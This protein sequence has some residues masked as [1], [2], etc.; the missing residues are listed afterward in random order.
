MLDKMIF[1]KMRMP[2]PGEVLPGRAEPIETAQ[3]HYVNGRAL[4][5]DWQAPLKKIMFGMGCFWG[6]ERLLWQQSGVY[7]TASGYAGG[8]TPNPTY[9]ETCTG[10]TG[11]AEVVLV[12]YNSEVLSLDKLLQIFWQAHDPTQ[13]MAQGADI[14]TSYRSAIYVEDNQDFEQALHSQKLY[15]QAL[16]EN[17]LAASQTEIA[18]NFPFYYAESHHQQY[19][20]KNPSG[21]CGLKGTGV[22][23]PLEQFPKSVQRFSD[24]NCGKNKE[25]EQECDSEIAHFALIK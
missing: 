18:M 11:H 4:K 15:D 13:Y 16:G 14:G 12:V 9:E 24:K 23:C 6:A 5:E 3:Y 8:F 22:A 19:L 1:D 2:Q 7:V 25:L 20:A 10:R 21:Y 17:G